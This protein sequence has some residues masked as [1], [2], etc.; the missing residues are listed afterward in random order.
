MTII[1]ASRSSTSVYQTALAALHAGISCIPILAD[2]TK[3]PA[4]KWKDYQKQRPTFH[5]I[6]TLV[7]PHPIRHSLYHR[8]G[9]RGWKCSI[10]TRIP[11]IPALRRLCS[12]KD[13]QGF[14]HASSMDTRNVRQRGCT[15]TIVAPLL[16]NA[17][18]N[19]PNVL[20]PNRHISP[21]SSRHAAKVAIALE[22]PQAAVFIPADCHIWCKVGISQPSQRF[23]PKSVLCCSLLPV[24]LTRSLPLTRHFPQ[25]VNCRRKHI[26]Q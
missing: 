6:G 7:F 24:R 17:I 4:I 23:Y 5:E 10:S 9:E 13:W 2:G 11:S 8:R 16:C 18:K 12:K 3:S 22:H 25:V 26:W 14:L 1:P 15:S 20:S 19:W 21:V